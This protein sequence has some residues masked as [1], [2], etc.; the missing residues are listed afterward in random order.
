MKRTLCLSAV[1]LCLGII[2]FTGMFIAYKQHVKNT[3]PPLMEES[4]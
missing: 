2:L 4:K 1:T 3:L